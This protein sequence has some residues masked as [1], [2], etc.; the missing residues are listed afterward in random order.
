MELSSRTLS[1][2][3]SKMA[4][5]FGNTLDALCS[6]HLPDTP[7]KPASKKGKME[8]LENVV[9]ILSSIS[10]LINQCSDSLKKLVTSNA[11]KIE[12]LK[13]TVDFVSA[14][15]KDVKVKVDN[16]T[17]GLQLGE[18]QIETCET[19]LADLERYSKCWKLR[20]RGVPEKE[21]NIRDEVIR[22][23][24]QTYPDGKGKFSFAID[25]VHRLGKK[26]NQI[27]SK[28]VPRAVI[29]QFTSRIVRNAVWKAAKSSAYLKDFCLSPL[30]G[31]RQKKLWPMAEEAHAA[32]KA[33][34]YV[35]AHTFINAPFCG[36]GYRRR[37][38][39]ASLKFLI[40]SYDHIYR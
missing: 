35:G 3:G 9:A 24:E 36:P 10:S 2:D 37:T 22:I 19:C 32:G 5:C 16:L 17:S 7:T 4:A 13:K 15:V 14:E 29:E 1:G 40:T 20:L 11:M 6:T 18:Q 34:Y 28:S 26:Q 27:G 23:C 12:G 21:E 31:E 30:D 38:L 39:Q 8:T 25:S 33:A